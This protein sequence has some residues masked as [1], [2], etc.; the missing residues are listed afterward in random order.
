MNKIKYLTLLT[1]LLCLSC[2]ST[3]LIS[4]SNSNNSDEISSLDS[5]STDCN[6]S[7][8]SDTS[9]NTSTDDSK[10][11]SDTTESTSS[12][13]TTEFVPP[14][15]VNYYT[16]GDTFEFGKWSGDSDVFDIDNEP[17]LESFIYYNKV[18][19][20]ERSNVTAKFLNDNLV[21]FPYVN[22][23][24]YSTKDIDVL[25]KFGEID[26]HPYVFGH[27]I[28]VEVGKTASTYSFKLRNPWMLE[29]LD[30]INIFPQVDY[31]DETAKGLLVIK[32][33]YF[34]WEIPS[35]STVID[36]MNQSTYSFMQN[37]QRISRGG[38]YTDISW[39]RISLE[40]Q[41]NREVNI[42]STLTKEYAPILRPLNLKGNNAI[43]LRI[44]NID[45][46]LTNMTF[47]LRGAK[48]SLVESGSSSY[49]TYYQYNLGRY[50]LPGTNIEDGIETISLDLR[51]AISSIGSN[52]D[53]D[54]LVLVVYLES[55]VVSSVR[56]G[57]G[58]FNFNL[59]KTTLRKLV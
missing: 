12:D 16:G 2:T 49:W 26:Y 43:D 6:T 41:L 34:S 58:A 44:E 14:E 1:A 59:Y 32:K 42:S 19:K 13:S 30:T 29:Y 55:D 48:K 21:E 39:T 11:E 52:I 8:D 33:A 36:G 20:D 17:N 23:E 56:L 54:G 53:S 24:M 4:D 7:T 35:N 22:F 28:T 45:N 18:N 40:K 51:T 37:G 38:W 15:D 5:T 50:E 3:D 9:S 27:E 57:D 31:N 47:I 46:S 10:S 25:I